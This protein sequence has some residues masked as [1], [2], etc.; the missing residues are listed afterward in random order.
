MTRVR[1]EILLKENSGKLATN[2]EL[3][4]SVPAWDKG[5]IRYFVIFHDR[6]LGLNLHFQNPEK[7]LEGYIYVLRPTRGSGLPRYRVMVN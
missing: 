1:R 5:L 4:L 2:W 7:N 3:S 6:S